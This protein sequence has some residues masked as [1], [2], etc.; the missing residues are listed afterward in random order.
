[1]FYFF[2]QAG[3]WVRH[4]VVT[5]HFSVCE[6]MCPCIC[7]LSIRLDFSEP[8]LLY[9]CINFIIIWHN[10]SDLNGWKCHL[11]VLKSGSK[12]R[13]WRLVKFSRAWHFVHGQSSRFVKKFYHMVK[14]L[15]LVTVQRRWHDVCSSNGQICS[16]KLKWR[17]N[18]GK[19]KKGW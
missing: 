16:C 17:K 9:L 10:Y 2:S 12:L 6:C 5:R 3:M 4:I 7:A 18:C 11:K 8:D 15:R 14:L 19:S 1:M 13:S